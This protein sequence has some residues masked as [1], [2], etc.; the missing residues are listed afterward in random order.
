V[1]GKA[2]HLRTVVPVACR[3]CRT[4]C[5][6]QP[7]VNASAPAASRTRMTFIPRER[8]GGPLALRTCFQNLQ[9]VACRF[10]PRRS[11]PPV[12]SGRAPCERPTLAFPNMPCNRTLYVEGRGARR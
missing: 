8:P 6:L 12:P 1:Q 7:P 10:Q 2:R 3:D 5:R 4:T 9:G 11:V